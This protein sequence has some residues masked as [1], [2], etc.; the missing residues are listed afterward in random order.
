MLKYYTKTATGGSHLKKRTAC[1]DYSL[2]F[3]DEKRTIITA[4][5][6]HGGAMYVRSSLGSKFA[7]FAAMEVMNG[8]DILAQSK[9]AYN[10]LRRN[11]L[12]SWNAA[13]ESDLAARPLADA[14]FA[15]LTA[16]QVFR[17]RS[18][19]FTAYGTTMNAAM[20]CADKI[21][22]AGI[23]DGGVFLIK[24]SELVP[25]T[26]DDEEETVANITYS[27]CQSDAFD[28]IKVGAAPLAEYDGVLVC[29]DGLIN[30]YR[31]LCNFNKSFVLPAIANI[32]T[33]K[34]A[35]LDNYIV[36]LA[37]RLGTGDDVSFG[38]ILKDG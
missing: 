16:D 15:S 35:A 24:G 36:N 19:P 37:A 33:G 9:D 6:G 10:A 38:I 1:Q 30:P 12:C 13:V 23:G 29:T 20:V 4:C 34:F 26:H 14:E 31:E 8:A 32:N 3:H 25:V 21:V 28:H 7:A 5:D 27:M 2:C 22:Y 11:I 18:D 17:L